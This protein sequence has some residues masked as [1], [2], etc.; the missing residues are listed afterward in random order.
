M[1]G[2]AFRL[3]SLPKE[4]ITQF[5]GSATGAAKPSFTP[6]VV[7]TL[8]RCLSIRSNRK[9]TRVEVSGLKATGDRLMAVRIADPAFLRPRGNRERPPRCQLRTVRDS[10]RGKGA[11]GILSSGT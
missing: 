5:D 2:G 4:A 1:R 7:Y 11:I 9:R 8:R 6:I 3:G 10:V